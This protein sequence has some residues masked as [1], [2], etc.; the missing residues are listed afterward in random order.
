MT[1]G[2][3]HTAVVFGG[4]GFIGSH[5]VPALEGRG[6]AVTVADIR[7]PAFRAPHAYV[8]VRH[9][10]DLELDR[11]PDLVV[12]LAAVHRSPGHQSHEY[13]ETNVRGA[14]EVTEWSRRAGAPTIVFTSSIAV[15]GPGENARTE[16]SPCAPDTPYG[17]AKLLAERVHTAWAGSTGG[18]AVVVRPASIFGRGS[19]GNFARLAAALRS[20]RFVYPGRTDTVK[21]CGYVRD[22]VDAVCF[23]LD[24]DELGTGAWNFGYPD[25]YTVQDVCEALCAIGGFARPRRVPERA[26]APIVLAARKGWGPELVQ[27]VHK[28]RTSTNVAPAALRGLGYRWPTDLVGGL[29]AWAKESDGAFT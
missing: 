23:L 9:P 24:R 1:P 10:I 17:H 6:A 4:A 7:E 5:L 2:E 11:A 28:A 3:I 19:T 18:R 22:L 29:D 12:N 14:I 8:D 20:G 21:S 13:Y 16:A 15:Y 27:Q 25:A 26:L